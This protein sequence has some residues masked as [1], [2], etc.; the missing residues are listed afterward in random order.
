VDKLWTNSGDSHFIE[1]RDLFRENLPRRL[2]DRLPRSERHG[3]EEVVHIDGKVLRRNVPKPTA[4]TARAM[5]EFRDAML[6]GGEGQGNGKVRLGHLDDQGV[7]GEVV[8]PSLGLWYGQIEDPHLVHEAAKVLNDFVADERRLRAIERCGHE[9]GRVGDLQH[10]DVSRRVGG[11]DLHLR[12]LQ[13]LLE[14]VLLSMFG[15]LIGVAIGVVVGS[16]KIGSFQLVVAPFWARWPVMRPR[17][18]SSQSM[19]STSRWL[20]GS[21]SSNTSGDDTKA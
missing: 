17:N 13:A 20:V 16:L 3:D 14:A 4:D 15:G 21:S 8:F 6:Q 1:P 12:L 18:S 10:G 19:A 11:D 9:T 2:A 5:T 7:W